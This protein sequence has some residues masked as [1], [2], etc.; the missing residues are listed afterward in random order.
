MEDVV[1]RAQEFAADIQLPA[2][3]IGFDEIVRL[4]GLMSLI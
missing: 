1:S 3:L 4:W 2:F